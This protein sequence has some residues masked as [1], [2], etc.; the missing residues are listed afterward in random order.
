M[1][2]RRDYVKRL[3]FNVSA[4]LQD[5]ITVDVNKSL[6]H[7]GVEPDSNSLTRIRN[8][9]STNTSSHFSPAKTKLTDLMSPSDFS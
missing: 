6:Q 7:Q 8:T 5:C 1:L 4:E 3:A 2:F 9:R